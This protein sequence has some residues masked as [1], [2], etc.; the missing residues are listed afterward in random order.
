MEMELE[1]NTNEY[2]PITEITEQDLEEDKEGDDGSH[3]PYEPIISHVASEFLENGR[4]LFPKKSY[5][6]PTGRPRGRPRG[7]KSNPERH[8]SPKKAAKKPTPTPGG[9]CETSRTGDLF[10]MALAPVRLSSAVRL[11]PQLRR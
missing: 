6:K 9:C 10:D 2:W 5:Y 4:G 1:G 7:S 3:P 8:M 11:P